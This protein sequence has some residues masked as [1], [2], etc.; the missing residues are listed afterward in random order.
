M[1]RPSHRFA[2]AARSATRASWRSRAQT[3][4]RAWALTQPQRSGNLFARGAA[5]RRRPTN[6]AY[7]YAFFK[8]LDGNLRAYVRA[9]GPAYVA[10]LRSDDVIETIDGTAW[11]QYGT[12]PS[13]QKPYDGKPH[14]L[15]VLRGTQS[16]D[17]RLGAPFTA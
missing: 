13:Q 8:T 6:R 4:L 1:A 2:A 17:I 16:L 14:S 7:F 9:G 10:G 11:W 12:Y 15:G 3:R 5:V